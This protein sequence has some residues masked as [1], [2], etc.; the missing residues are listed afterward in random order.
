MSMFWNKKTMFLTWNIAAGADDVPYLVS[1][2]DL[3]ELDVVVNQDASGKTWAVSINGHV[4]TDGIETAAQ[5]QLFAIAGV[6]ERLAERCGNPECDSESL[7]QIKERS[8]LHIL[9]RDTKHTLTRAANYA[10]IY[11]KRVNL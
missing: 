6:M 2:V 1:Q 10:T 3:C 4:W 11:A 9:D 7:E 5:A 8:I